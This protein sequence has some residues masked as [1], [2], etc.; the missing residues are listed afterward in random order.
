MMALRNR[1]D[2]CRENKQKRN[3]LMCSRHRHIMNALNMHSIAWDV[4]VSWF[5][6]QKSSVIRYEV[7]QLLKA[8]DAVFKSGNCE[9]YS[10]ARTNLKKGIRS[11]KQ[12]YT[13][14]REDHFHNSIWRHSVYHGLQKLQHLFS[15]HNAS[16]A[17][18]FLHPLQQRR[19]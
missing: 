1:G 17:K 3:I 14:W 5:V 13:L 9:A 11:A 15:C 16:R 12:N 10:I 4:S 8:H 18:S 19:Y 2:N 6:L 7:W